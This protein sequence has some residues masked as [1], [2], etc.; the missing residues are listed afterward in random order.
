M[1][2]SLELAQ[3]SAGFAE[4][5]SVICA[6]SFQIGGKTD[7]NLRKWEAADFLGGLWGQC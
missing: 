5:L 4:D 1:Q 2:F 7:P 3:K 6:E